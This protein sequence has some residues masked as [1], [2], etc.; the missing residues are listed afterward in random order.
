MPYCVAGR[1]S[2]VRTSVEVHGAGAGGYS[3]VSS[4]YV[5]TLQ[6]DG[7]SYQLKTS[8]SVPVSAGDHVAVAGKER[9]GIRRVT[10]LVN[11]S[12][13]FAINGTYAL[14]LIFGLA[15]VVGPLLV[16]WYAL[17]QSFINQ[18]LR[19]SWAELQHAR[20]ALVLVFI[21][22]A[23]GMFYLYHA[24]FRFR[25]IERLRALPAEGTTGGVE[26]VGES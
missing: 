16:A 19:L 13:G 24:V 12:Q 26:H 2:N 25:C 23:V 10:V 6:V 3:T 7:R 11:H 22:V 17:Q 5:T 14:G 8:E 21:P 4:T 18:G 1:C 9:G 20:G 15:L